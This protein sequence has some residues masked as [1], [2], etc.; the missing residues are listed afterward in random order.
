MMKKILT[1]VLLF[2]FVTS[3][4]LCA[5]AAENS[6]PLLDK[7][8]RVSEDGGDLIA[9]PEDDLIDIIGI[10]PEYYTDFAY[11]ASKDT[12]NGR[13][14][15]VVR[16]ADEKAAKLVVELLEDYRENRIRCTRNYYAEAY[17]ALSESEVLQED[18]LIVLSIGAPD[19]REPDLLLQEE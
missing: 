7:A 6:E 5:C 3:A 16:A 18:L 1:L 15:I 8:L 11:L 13:E 19:P 17:R 9:M 2:C 4:A 12:S 14:I 10:E